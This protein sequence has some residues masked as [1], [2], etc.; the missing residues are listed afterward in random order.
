M[1][2]HNSNPSEWYFLMATLTQLLSIMAGRKFSRKQCCQVTNKRKIIY[3]EIWKKRIVIFD[4]EK[5]NNNNT[6][7]AHRAMKAGTTES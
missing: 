7:P 5:E 6:V 3:V 4:V 2:T 1:L